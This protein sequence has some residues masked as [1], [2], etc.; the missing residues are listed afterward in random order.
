MPPNLNTETAEPIADPEEEQ[1]ADLSQ[2]DV[3]PGFEADPS[4]TADAESDPNDP[5]FDPK[6]VD[7]WQSRWQKQVNSS[8][9]DGQRLSALN[10][11]VEGLE[12]GDLQATRQLKTLSQ[13]NPAE[14]EKI[15]GMVNALA[16]DGAPAPLPAPN[17]TQPGQDPSVIARLT[18]LEGDRE[19]SQAER[20]IAQDTRELKA[21]T[22]FDIDDPK[23]DRAARYL[24]AL[25]FSGKH[26]TAVIAYEKEKDVIARLLDGPT[27]QQQM[28]RRLSTLAG[29]SFPSNGVPAKPRNVREGYSAAK[30]LFVDIM[31]GKK[32][33]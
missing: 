8:K 15:M 21:K 13:N 2:G 16:T 5:N 27:Q 25:V 11:L 14:F 26:P 22:G 6:R 19:R 28:G 29:S 23:N 1:V 30:Q 31:K 4:L 17:V 32:R 18:E 20:S 24:G 12:D 3:D 10:E 9:A 33:A 7:H